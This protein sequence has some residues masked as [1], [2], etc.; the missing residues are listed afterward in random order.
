MCDLDHNNLLKRAKLAPE[1]V[2]KEITKV[3]SRVGI[4][5]MRKVDVCVSRFAYLAQNQL[6]R[7]V[8]NCR[9]D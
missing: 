3:T 6:A 4:Q 8:I 2:S 1:Q 9:T 5:P 7:Q